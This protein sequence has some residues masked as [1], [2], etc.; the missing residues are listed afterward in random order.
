MQQ[1]SRTSDPADRQQLS[2]A[3]VTAADQMK[4]IMSSGLMTASAAQCDGCSLMQQHQ[5][6]TA[7][8][9][10]CSSSPKQQQQSESAAAGAATLALVQQLAID[11][12]FTV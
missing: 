7:A 1:T 11:C 9:V 6:D 8:A 12:P 4:N 2:L 5:S 10:Q 3:G